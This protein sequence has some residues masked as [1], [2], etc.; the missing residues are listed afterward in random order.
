LNGNTQRDFVA[1][2]T[3]DL[4]GSFENQLFTAAESRKPDVPTR[5]FTASSMRLS[6]GVNMRVD[7][8]TPMLEDLAAFQFTLGYDQSKV[9]LVAVEPGLVPAAYL[10][11]FADA[12][13]V[14]AACVLP[15]ALTGAENKQKAVAF[16]LIIKAQEDCLLKDVLFMNGSVTEKAA[17]TGKLETAEIGL[18][19]LSK[20]S[21]KP[22]AL[23]M[24]AVPNPVQ[25]VLTAVYY[26]PEEGAATLRLT[27]ATGQVVL[28]A[29]AE[30]AQ[31]M[32][33]QVLDLSG[34]SAN[35]LLLLQLETAGGVV[36]QKVM[37]V[38]Q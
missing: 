14:T 20:P 21:G 22:S 30:S 7:I 28:Q 24:P 3:G 38:R 12:G 26:L 2:K 16:T 32:H 27:D 4:D 11:Q 19:F 34:L 6:A 17:F 31:G 25:D 10:G 23:L 36:T 15:A 13:A 35:G 5:N 37:R 9:Q 1:M 8:T 33:N 18:E 29:T